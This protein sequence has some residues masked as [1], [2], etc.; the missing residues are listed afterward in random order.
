[1]TLRRRV[2]QWLRQIS[3]KLWLRLTAAVTQQA[4]YQ[5]WQRPGAALAPVPMPA[6][7][8]CRLRLWRSSLRLGQPQQRQGHGPIHIP[9]ALLQV[10]PRAKA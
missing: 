4:L 10:L 5:L 7:P 9:R 8:L 1:M 3:N 2:L 6:V